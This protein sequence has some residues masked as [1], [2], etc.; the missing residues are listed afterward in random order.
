MRFSTP[1]GAYEIDSVPSQPQV[2]HCHGF[3]VRHEL[4]GGGLA[5]DLKCHQ[6]AMLL[7]LGYDFATCTVCRSN[8]RQ[9]KVLDRA[10]WRCL[11]SFVSSKA[12]EHVELW[13]FAVRDRFIDA[14]DDTL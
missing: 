9:K 5:H 7:R 10:G 12:G 6:T 11:A 3:F 4:R 14:N 2:A 13:G 1:F 8:E